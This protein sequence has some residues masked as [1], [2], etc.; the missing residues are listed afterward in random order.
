MRIPSWIVLMMTLLT[1]AGCSTY[2]VVTDYDSSFPFAS[3]KTYRWSDDAITKSSSNVLANNPLVLKRIKNA[4]DRELATK[5]YVLNS[6]GAADF[7]V[8]LYAGVQDRERYNLPPMSFSYHQGYYHNRFGH[9]RFGHN[10]FVMYDPYWPTPYVSYYKAGT[11]VIDI[12][13]QKS[14]ELAWRGIAQGILQNYNTGKEMQQD[15]DGA[16]TKILAEFPP[17]KR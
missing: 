15:I 2:S 3:Y 7:T 8:S 11:L 13:D 16:V 1:G 10:R 4:V 14:N 9:N 6:N 17:L 5:G 12:M